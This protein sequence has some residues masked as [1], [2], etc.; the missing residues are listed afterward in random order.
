MMICTNRPGTSKSNR[1][2]G[3]RISRAVRVAFELKDSVMAETLTRIM[4]RMKAV[5]TTYVLST[6]A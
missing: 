2:R 6:A 3:K 4:R 1:A 5:R